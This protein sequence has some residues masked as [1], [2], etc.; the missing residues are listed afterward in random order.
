MKRMFLALCCYFSI[1][2]ALPCCFAAEA[3]QRAPQEEPLPEVRLEGVELAEPRDTIHHIT[4]VDIQ[5]K[6]ATSL[7]EALSGV[8][9]ITLGSS[10]ARNEGFVQIRGSERRQVSLFIDD[11]PIAT[12]FRNE[13]D[14]NRV[15]T[16]DLESIEVSKG[17][18][19][20]HFG[21]NGLGGVIN[22]RT[23]KPKK[24]FEANLRYM[25]FFDRRADDQG[26]LFAARLGTLQEKFYVKGTFIQQIQDHFTLSKDFK[27]TQ[28]EDGGRRDHSEFR[29]R[30]VN[31]MAGF[32]PTESVDIRLNYSRQD[33]RRKNP[34][35]TS[36]ATNRA[37][38]WTW[39]DYDTERVSI[40]ADVN[41]TDK[42][43]TSF[44]VYHDKHK[45]TSS[46]YT[47]PSLINWDNDRTYDQ[48][49]TGGRF[50][51]DYAFNEA[52]KLSLSAAFRRNSHKEYN[53]TATVSNSLDVHTQE[54]YWDFGA[55]YTW[56]PVK[57]LTLVF[58]GSYTLMD[59]QKNDHVQ[60][61]D[62]ASN[63]PQSQDVFNEQ[64]GIFYEFVDKHELFATVAHKS[65]IPSAF[66]RYRLKGRGNDRVLANPDLKH[67]Q[68][69]HYELGYRGIFENKLKVNSS[70]FYSNVKDLI[71]MRDG[72]DGY[73]YFTNVN[74]VEY[75]GWEFATELHLN[76]YLS[77]G[78]TYTWMRWNT[79]NDE[80][81]LT[82]R[83]EHAA[84]LY[85][86]ISPIEGL[87]LTPQLNMMSSFYSYY[88]DQSGFAPK[89]SAFLT[90][91]FKVE[92]AITDFLSVEAGVRNIFDK[93]YQYDYGFP[94]PG[95]NYFAGVSITF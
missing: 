49:A 24:E 31:F 36:Q 20:P 41:W 9:G 32:T 38:H 8:P 65:R 17:Y 16:M 83:P 60:L 90:A 63:I 66:E 67:E 6:T 88:S 53:T 80:T 27:A 74:K 10:G 94:E 50:L 7:W 59:T 78:L 64:F 23:S 84:T 81:K 93:N 77:G 11:V 71:D 55:E 56:K 35:D 15:L 12:T 87:T 54:N 46:A 5:R 3:S 47:E 58:G 1:F 28:Y 18:S 2:V 68:A 39:P 62:D 13:Y 51:A 40:N 37:R 42:F 14:L 92:Y 57:R 26:R 25:N 30:R 22:M 89:S 4:Q 34:F 43:H 73:S 95:R 21:S 44:V 48:Y 85:A 91:D 76:E 19:S 29:D 86:V 61:A 72:S 52:H 79:L 70:L 33:S 69:M 75:F 45:D 82:N